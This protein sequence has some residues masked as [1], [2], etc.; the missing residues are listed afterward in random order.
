ME[1]K[2]ASFSSSSSLSSSAALAIKLQHQQLP[3]YL[4]ACFSKLATEANIYQLVKTSISQREAKRKATRKRDE[5]VKKAQEEA[6][7]KLTALSQIKKS[8]APGKAALLSGTLRKALGRKFLD[9][10]ARF[11]SRTEQTKN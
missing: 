6:T 3:P 5:D 9:E 8:K 11:S 10:L 2:S 7:R 1:V 4:F